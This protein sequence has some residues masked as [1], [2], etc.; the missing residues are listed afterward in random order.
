MT[1]LE[2]I[3]AELPRIVQGIEVSDP[4]VVLYGDGWNLS[5]MCPWTLCGPDRGSSWE[6]SHIA[7]DVQDLIVHMLV[8]VSGNRDVIDPV[9][10]FDGGIDIA[11][12]AD[13][14]LDP[15]TLTLPNLVAVTGR[16]TGLSQSP[17]AGRAQVFDGS[18]AQLGPPAVAV[19]G[20]AGNVRS[21]EMNESDL[22]R[23]AQELA[24]KTAVDPWHALM[25]T[26]LMQL[27]EVDLPSE[28]DVPLAIADAYWGSR[29]GTS[30]DLL[31]ARELTWVYVQSLP[32]GEDLV[33][34]GARLAR[35]VLCVLEPAGDDE[36]ISMTA[37]WFVAMIGGSP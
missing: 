17:L 19:I 9:F 4:V 35:A 12:Y 6:S 10:H 22:I 7:D 18:T 1:I 24:R 26:L 27:R 28:V 33:L 3:S 23:A 25:L 20:A 30:D 31:R 8:S 36:S 15:W 2:E 34:R 29:E 11:V 21:H 32:G 37:E 13:T 5:L 14:D 16:Q